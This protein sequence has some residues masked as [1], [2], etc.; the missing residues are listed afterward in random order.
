MKPS[1]MKST[2]LKTIC[3]RTETPSRMKSPIGAR[4]FSCQGIP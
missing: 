4:G 2:T 1:G 3:G